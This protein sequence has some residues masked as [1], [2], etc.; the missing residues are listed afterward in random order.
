MARIVEIHPQ[1]PQRRLTQQ[2]V[3]TLEAGG[4]I[5]YPTDS[6]YALGCK[7]GNAA[8][9]ERIRK[10]RGDVF[11][12]RPKLGKWDWAVLAGRSLTM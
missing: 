5:A 9:V 10:I 12:H 1:N 6:G 11:R 2:V 8:G 4:L 3:D 7:L